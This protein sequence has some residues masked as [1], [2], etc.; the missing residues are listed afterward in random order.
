MRPGAGLLQVRA[1]SLA[2]GGRELLHEANL[3][4]AE[5]ECVA[6]TGPSG[7][8]KTSLLNCIAGITTPTSGTVTILGQHISG[9]RSELRSAFRLRHLGLVF[10]FGELIPELTALE[11]AAFPSRLLGVPL[12]EAERRAMS[13]LERLG[14]GK[15]ASRHPSALS[16]GEVQ[17]VGIARALAHSP[18]L[19]LADEPT[20]MLDESNS[21]A[22]ANLLREVTVEA[23]VAVLIA[24]HDVRVATSADRIVSLSQKSLVDQ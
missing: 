18:A 10:Q 3:E 11:N 5:G 20:G 14:V 6:L 9:A 7:V 8:G 17:R 15:E 4:L 16:G 19:L 13:W 1:I 2:V 12:R 21:D 23:G 22:V 24:T